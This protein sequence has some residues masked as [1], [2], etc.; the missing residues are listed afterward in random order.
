MNI[1][2]HAEVKQLFLNILS[3]KPDNNTD[4][5]LKHTADQDVID[6]VLELVH[7]YENNTR[8]TKD[9]VEDI[10][11]NI[12][13]S[14]LIFPSDRYI[15]IEKIGQGGMG[16]VYLAQR[17]IEGI[18]QKVAIKI[19]HKSDHL[20]Q[21][22]FLQEATILSQ[23]SHPHISQFIDAD[24][25]NDG[26]PY[27]VMEYTRGKTIIE[28]CQSM[29]ADVNTRLN[30]FMSLCDAV[31]HAHR[32]LIIHRDI[33]PDNIIVNDDGELKLLDFGIAKIMQNDAA[34]KTHTQMHMMTPAY[35]S[36]E[37]YLG[38][39]V[40][41]SSDV[42]SLGVV[43]YEL[44]SGAR[45]YETKHHSP[46]EYEKSLKNK[47]IDK[48][49]QK[50]L[51]RAASD[52]NDVIINQRSAWS[53]KLSG[54]LDTIVLKSLEYDVANRYQTVAEF[55]QD[56]SRYDLDLPIQAR[57]FGHFYQF[58]KFIKR[59]TLAFAFT[60][61]SL[62]FIA[63]F[64][65]VILS[66]NE[67]I[68]VQAKNLAIQRDEAQREQKRAETLS[69]AFIQAFNNAD[70][71]KSNSKNITAIEVMKQTEKL[72]EREI[73]DDP[74]V[75]NQ[76][77]IS[78]AQVYGNLR[79]TKRAE[80]LL[81]EV[82]KSYDSLSL[83][84]KISF[85]NEKALTLLYTGQPQEVLFPFM[86]KALDQFDQ[87]PMLFQTYGIILIHMNMYQKAEK[88]F[89]HYLTNIDV[90]NKYYLP[91]CSTYGY[92]VFSL[93]KFA[94]AIKIYDSCIEKSQ[95]HNTNLWEMS[96][97]Y[98]QYGRAHMGLKQPENAL[99]SF[100]KAKQLRIEMFGEEHTLST[101]MSSQ[102]GYA[103]VQANKPNEALAHIEIGLK[104][105]QKQA[106]ATNIKAAVVTPLYIKAQ[107][108][109]ALDKKV[110]AEQLFIEIIELRKLYDA[111]RLYN[112]AHYY[113]ELGQVR[114]QLNK[115]EQ[116]RD[117]FIYSIGIFAREMYQDFDSV[118]KTRILLADCLIRLNEVDEAVEVL[119]LVIEDTNLTERNENTIKADARALLK[120]INS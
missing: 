108:Y 118:A 16:D 117:S 64:M 50:V 78:I 97:L 114:V 21:E 71:T 47:A 96:K 111:D 73:I 104:G 29:K 115:L 40:N 10:A 105:R 113:K 74:I 56:I 6:K 33:K 53:K 19:L 30:L 2:Q 95:A 37:Q 24:F 67:S 99:D 8:H 15:L 68:K 89:K 31:E 13:Q 49:S 32:N 45:P 39:S 9:F 58:K 120:N 20:S 3:V 87:H 83:Q 57:S 35:A 61:I 41:V 79:E 43:F 14:A 34:I 109:L 36:P 72:I 26:R 55:S 7:T 46:I 107:A 88:K 92:A 5:L 63:G 42:Y 112:S 85:T 93:E 65:A 82:E 77:L 119:K 75:K 48:P 101:D 81:S 59:H 102:I 12:S 86:E 66:Q 4:Y 22:R 103:L 1:Q 18:K 28:Y 94:D 76:L 110:E 23:L 17:K 84:D 69:N 25:L 51:K 116:A 38:R 70:P 52:A 27:V 80:S 91:L 98:F 54:D 100:H 60:V 90:K 44:L 62:F 106:E 11:E